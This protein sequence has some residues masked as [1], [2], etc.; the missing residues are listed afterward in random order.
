MEL[1]CVITNV[2]PQISG[3]SSTTGKEWIK[4]EFIVE[5]YDRFPKKIFMS[6]FGAESI[7]NNPV[8]VGMPAKVSFDIES[9]AYMCRDGI[10]RWST[11]CRA[12]KVEPIMEQSSTP[13]FQP[14]QTPQPVQPAQPQYAMPQYAEPQPQVAAQP[15]QAPQ[16]GNEELPF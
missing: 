9:R 12:W 13:Q 10:E 6:I 4:Q 7:E 8:T 15:S 14:A 16:S 3:V 2:L 5:T 11:E 1:K